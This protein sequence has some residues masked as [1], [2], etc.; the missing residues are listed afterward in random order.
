VFLFVTNGLGL[1]QSPRLVTSVWLKPVV[2]WSQVAPAL[3]I[4]EEEDNELLDEEELIDE[5]DPATVVQT[6]L[7][8][9][10]Y[11]LIP[12]LFLS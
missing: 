4:L 12:C 8:K 1:A 7:N 9:V 11:I 10:G 3:E 5:R 2:E 6:S